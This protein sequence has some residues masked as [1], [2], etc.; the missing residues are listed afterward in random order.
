M[1]AVR[2]RGSGDGPSLQTGRMG[3]DS[4]T[5][6]GPSVCGGRLGRDGALHHLAG[7]AGAQGG[8]AS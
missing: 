8:L 1:T 4:H 2:S 5:A 7:Q 3:A 6:K